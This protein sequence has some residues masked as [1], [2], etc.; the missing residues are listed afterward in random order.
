M[1]FFFFFDLGKSRRVFGDYFYVNI[2]F[3]ARSPNEEVPVGSRVQEEGGGQGPDGGEGGEWTLDK[4]KSA[5][6][7]GDE[8][9][10]GIQQ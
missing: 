8:E 9:D 1:Y 6:E 7:R 2:S 10:T 3:C 4:I 5:L